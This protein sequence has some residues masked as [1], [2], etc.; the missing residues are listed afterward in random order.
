[1]LTRLAIASDLPLWV[2]I[3]AVALAVVSVTALAFYELPLRSLRGVVVAFSGVIASL[4]LVGAVLRPVM[5]AS[6]ETRLG[7]KVVVL[8][9]ASRSMALD[10]GSTRRERVRD[11]AIDSLQR[12]LSTARLSISAFG[13]GPATP[14]KSG[15]PMLSRSDLTA[16]LRSLAGSAEER[17][18]AVVVVS[19]GVWDDPT[20]DA[21]RAAIS[22]ASDLLGIPIHTIGTTRTSPPDASVRRVGTPGAVVAH[23]PFSLH[24]EVGC[25]GGLACDNLTVT[26]R[27]LRENAPPAVLAKGE[28]ALRDGEGS[29]DLSVT[30][31]RAGTRIVEV[32]VASKEGDAIAENDKRLIP[33]QV[34]RE[35]LRILHVAGRPT[36]DVSALR[37]WL[38]SD[39]SIDMVAFFILLTRSDNP[40]ARTDDL[41]L[42]PFPVDELFSEHLPSFDA[43]ILQD[44]DAQPY[45]LERHL[46]TLARYVRSGGGLIMVGGQNA[47][48]A[49][50]YAN[51]PLADVLPVS[52]D[53]SFGATAADV[54]RVVPTWTERGRSA[55]LMAALRNLA[56]DELPEMTGANV[57]GDVRPSSLALWV[58]P[59]RKTASGAPMPLLAI[60]DQ[61]E[62]R[63]IAL[64]LDG[65]WLLEFSK[66]GARTAGRGYASLWDGLLGWLM[67]DPRFELGQLEFLAP[68]IAHQPTR[69]RVRTPASLSNVTLEV[70][71]L[72]EGAVPVRI[73]G[74]GA[75]IAEVTLPPLPSGGYTGHL[76]YGAGLVTRRDFAC[77]AGG[78][79]WA[80]SRPD[81][82][83]LRALASASGGTFRWADDNLSVPVPAP[84][85]VSTERH[86]APLAP[87]WV[88]SL[89]AALA[90]GVHWLGRR[91]CGLA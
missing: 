1:M 91:R 13:D 27:E 38:K 24:V 73:E 5:I 88:W 55:P 82:D 87:P 60:G 9:D 77:E 89:V 62:G 76:Q 56:G 51:T 45:N 69:V 14:W 75:G 41:A 29:L 21:S 12:A 33:F 28:A 23:V 49:G 78:D 74:V 17:P 37:Q 72:V 54:S 90:L 58:H 67:R 11:A 2:A 35:R 32:S 84:T 8:A 83:R 15:T 34:T 3:G 36:N 20:A 43:V 79:E 50:G 26:A 44:F 81:P 65:G 47:F 46:P 85:V 80:D 66:L 25:A 68:C 19:D 39:P 52:L 30:L 71:Q 61:G 64:G 70:K 57:L 10:D 53:G 4:A 22:K 31:E 6:R 16:A 59:T 18:R 40:N 48:V 63:S 42:I 86:V 7:A